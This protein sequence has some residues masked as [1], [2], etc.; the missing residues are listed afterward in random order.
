MH[1]TGALSCP[2][3]FLDNPRGHLLVTSSTLTGLAD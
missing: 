2:R 1:F 3:G